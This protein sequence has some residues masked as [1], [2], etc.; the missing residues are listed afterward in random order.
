MA[1][2]CSAMMWFLRWWLLPLVGAMWQWCRSRS[3]IAPAPS[4]VDSATRRKRDSRR[5][6]SYKTRGGVGPD[7]YLP[8]ASPFLAFASMG[9]F[10]RKAGRV[11]Y[12]VTADAQIPV[13]APGMDELQRVGAIALLE[14]GFDAVEGIGR[15]GRRWR[16]STASS[17]PTPV[18][19]IEGLRARLDGQHFLPR[20]SRERACRSQ[21]FPCVS[22]AGTGR[23]GSAARSGR[24][25]HRHRRSPVY[26]RAA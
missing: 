12:V 9:R 3:G 10:G 5:A 15:P 19:P 20:E 26:G 8:R 16:S 4:T 11:M 24:L 6:I 1:M 2:S 21:R 23:R 25:A 14:Q 17:P 7:R 22:G 18:A 13:G